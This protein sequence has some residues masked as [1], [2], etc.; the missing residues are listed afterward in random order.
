MSDEFFEKLNQKINAV[1]ADQT[2]AADQL[3]MARA[4]SVQQIAHAS[5][6]AQAYA[7]QLKNQNIKVLLIPQEQSLSFSM[8][9]PDGTDHGFWLV[10]EKTTGKLQFKYHTTDCTDRRRS[11]GT[12]MDLYGSA[13]WKPEIFV[14]TL[15][16][17]IED[18]IEKSKEHGGLA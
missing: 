13:D 1:R 18:F 12:G 8:Y 14:D 17:E 6:V 4:Y 11:E 10:I 16:R 9:W 5:T 2:N 15:E 7:E 3:A